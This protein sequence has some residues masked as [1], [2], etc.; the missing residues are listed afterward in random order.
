MS[1]VLTCPTCRT[2]LRRLPS[3]VA[4]QKVSCP[5]CRNT[6]VV[7]ADD[8]G[9]ATLPESPGGRGSSEARS[10]PPEDFDRRDDRDDDRRDED[11]RDDRGRPGGVV[12]QLP[13]DFEVRLGPSWEVSKAHYSAYFG[14]AIGFFLI[15]A[16]ATGLLGLIPFFIGELIALAFAPVLYAGFTIV[17]LKQ[18]RG[19][20]WSFG[21]FFAG[22]NQYGPLV[23]QGLIFGLIQFLCL[24]PG[25]IFILI[26]QANTNVGLIA[27]GGALCLLG[28]IPVLVVYVR[29]FIF[30]VPLI[31]DR[32][33]NAIEAIQGTVRMTQGKFG[34]L[35]VVLLVVAGLNLAGAMACCVGL[36][37]TM[38]LTQL[39]LTAVYA[40]AEGGEPP[41]SHPAGPRDAYDDRR[42]D[43]DRRDDRRR[44]DFDRGDDRRRDDR[45]DDFDRGDDRRR[46]Y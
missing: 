6:F 12:D 21:D 44:D 39:L 29:C 2:T 19:R 8:A 26:G 34:P 18:L 40:D 31:V 30:A 1:D 42:D 38:P 7:P 45:R 10:R 22:F 36:L 33:F 27:A 23:I 20:N 35:F 32:R 46:D 3:L 17:T 28:L 11:F 14:P 15:Y 4:G 37:F 9:I 16:V 43:Y 25:R 24:L 13:T 41:L 5:S